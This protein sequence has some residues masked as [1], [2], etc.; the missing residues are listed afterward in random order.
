MSESKRP[1]RL[2]A[3]LRTLRKRLGLS[4]AALGAEV[5]LSRSNIASYENAKAEPRAAKLVEL[6]RYLNVS[7][8]VLVTGGVVE[9]DAATRGS[10]GASADA[11]SEAS[12]A[13]ERAFLRRRLS[14]VSA[15]N[16]RLHEALLELES[17]HKFPQ[18]P[19]SAPEL[20]LRNSLTVMRDLLRNDEELARVLAYVSDQARD[21]PGPYEPST[22]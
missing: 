11:P 3:N 9:L 19:P 7:V 1:T 15:R 5:G 17:L 18:L 14:E 20:H 4:Q 21:S 2:A 10:L 6:A 12:F 22:S 13:A 16:R 8:D